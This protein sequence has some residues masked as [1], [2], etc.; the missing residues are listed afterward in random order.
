MIDLISYM[1]L[2]PFLY[3]IPPTNG[4]VVITL[5]NIEEIYYEWFEELI[6]MI[7]N[8]YGFINPEDFNPEENI[9]GI[10]VLLTFDDGFLS[11]KI[12]SDKIL[13]KIRSK[14]ALF[15]NRRVCWFK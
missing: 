6:V 11:N 15:Y 13:S 12:I 5:H 9:D 1:I 7:Q 4:I 3:L 8:S 14:S 10:K 2:R